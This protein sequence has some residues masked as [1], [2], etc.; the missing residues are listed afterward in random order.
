MTLSEIMG[1]HRGGTKTYHVSRPSW[2]EGHYIEVNQYEVA[3]IDEG[4]YTDVLLTREDWDAD[5]WEIR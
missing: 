2:V 3:F 4:M 1:I 5:D